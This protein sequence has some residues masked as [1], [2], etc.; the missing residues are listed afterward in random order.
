MTIKNIYDIFDLITGKLGKVY[1]ADVNGGGKID[2]TIAEVAKTYE[3]DASAILLDLIPNDTID[4]LVVVSPHRVLK[5]A[6]SELGI[7]AEQ[8]LTDYDD[9][10][11]AEVVS[12]VFVRHMSSAVGNQLVSI[13]ENLG[14]EL[15]R[16]KE[17]TDA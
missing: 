16:R 5:E 12:K 7:D 9:E 3:A 13:H 15:K 2:Y 1:T 6:M 14:A 11:I 8:D 17:N 4:F 10:E